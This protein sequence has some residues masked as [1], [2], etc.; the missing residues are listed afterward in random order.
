MALHTELDIYKAA[1]DMLGLTIDELIKNMP[2]SV[3]RAVGDRLRDECI[4]LTVLIQTANMERD[5]APH[6]VAMLKS[7]GVVE[8]LLRISRDKRY[9]G[10]KGYA[11]AVLLT[12]SI[13]KQANALRRKFAPAA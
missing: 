6:F 1:Y 3:S 5:K 13:G 7:L 9:I 12:T 2:R 10:L 11:A 4:T 8:L